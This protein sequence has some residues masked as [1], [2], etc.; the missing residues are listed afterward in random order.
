M[1]L[2]FFLQNSKRDQGIINVLLSYPLVSKPNK[3]KKD[4]E[5]K[6]YD[7]LSWNE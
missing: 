6:Y 5:P 1:L 3:K 2:V 4:R 7:S